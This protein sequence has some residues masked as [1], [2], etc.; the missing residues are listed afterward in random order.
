MQ[1]ELVSYME[2]G[3]GKFFIIFNIDLA[4][5]SIIGLLI[6]AFLAYAIGY[7]GPFAFCGIFSS[8]YL[9]RWSIFT[10]WNFSIKINQ[11]RIKRQRTII[12]Q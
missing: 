6:S 4:L 11:F 9:L 8:F 2:F 5:G 3:V 7:V 12:T 1:E 10:V